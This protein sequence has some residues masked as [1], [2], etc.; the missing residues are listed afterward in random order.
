MVG[1]RH[2]GRLPILAI[3]AATRSR[4]EWATDEPFARR[5]ELYV[6]A[7]PVFRRHGYR[8]ATL[9]ALA[10]ACGLS[11]PALYRYFP[12]KKAFAL[13]PLAALYPELQAPP[14]DI[15]AGDPAIYLSGWIEGA[16]AEMPNYILAAKLLREV[17]LGDAE[18]LKMDANL[19]EHIALVGDLARRA[20]PHLSDATARELAST[21]INVALGPALTGIEPEPAALRRELRALLRGYGLRVP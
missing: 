9:K 8:G 1:W 19:A 16:V 7:A 21:M 13:F 6:Q 12:S 10:G 11:I 17:G 3:V 4:R 14:P 20:A 2:V 15:S 5:R 18:Q